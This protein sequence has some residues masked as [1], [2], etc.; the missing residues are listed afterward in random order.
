MKKFSFLLVLFSASVIAQTNT[1]VYLFDLKKT[2]NGYTL[3]NKKNIS[4]NKGYDSQPHF[5]DNHILLFSSSRNDQTDIAKYDIKTG[6]KV[7]INST[8]KGGEYSPQRI[9][10]SDDVS[11][12]R[13]DDSGLQRFYRYSI[14]NGESKE[15]IRSLKVAY[16]FWFNEKIVVSSIIGKGTLD[17]VISDLKHKTNFTIQK[18]IGRSIHRIPNT[19]KVSYISKKNENWEVR[20]LDVGN[21]RTAKIADLDGKYED[22][23]WLSDGSVLQAKKNQILRFDPKSSKEWEVFFTID[24]SEI[25]NISRIIVSPDGTMISIVGEE[26]P[27]FVVQKQLDA[28]NNRDIDAFVKVFAKDVKVYSYPNKLLYKGRDGMRKRYAAFFKNTKDLHCKIIKRVE[29][30]NYVIDEELVTANGKKIN[31]VAIYEVK[32]GKIITVTF[33]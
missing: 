21:L 4:Q 20:S 19:N 14:E 22:I 28:Y 5:Y 7:F 15:L 18:N 24:D 27:R 31:A 17:L 1:E 23:C 25:Q 32:D 26:S 13:L 29:K 12:V 2:D 33:L 11:A 30:G 3:V 16:P 6:K 10:K 9:P 8:P